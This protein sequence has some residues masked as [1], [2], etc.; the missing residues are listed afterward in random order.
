[1]NR[2][3]LASGDWEDGISWEFYVA[4]ELPPLEL[5]TAVMCVAIH[6]GK[7]VLARSKRGWGVLGGHIE[8]GESPTDALA[9]EA[10]EEGGYVID[11]H[12]LFAIKA[13]NSKKPVPHPTP[14]RFYPFPTGYMAY[15]WAESESPL[16]EYTGEEILESASF[17]IDQL[18]GME[19]RDQHIITAGLQAHGKA[20]TAQFPPLR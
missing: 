14:G 16:R 12:G 6:D 19:L 7:V 9:R 3:I 10:L 8:D 17:A 15:Y 5:C 18:V 2:E 11:R 20:R 13:I 4:D 1:M